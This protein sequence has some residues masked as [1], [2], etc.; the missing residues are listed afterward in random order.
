V[1]NSFCK[2]Q[3]TLLTSIL[4][5]TTY[6]YHPHGKE[7]EDMRSFAASFAM[8]HASTSLFNHGIGIAD[9]SGPRHHLLYGKL[10]TQQQHNSQVKKKRIVLASITMISRL[11]HAIRVPLQAM[12]GCG[13]LKPFTT[14]ER[15]C[16]SSSFGL[17]S[18][19]NSRS[20][21]SVSEEDIAE[22]TERLLQV[23]AD[24]G[25]SFNDIAKVLGLTNV[26]TT[27]LFLGQAKLST[28]AAKKLKEA[29]PAISDDDVRQMQT[30]FPM[31]VFDDDL[32]KEY[33]DEYVI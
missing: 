12:N 3:Y 7:L 21:S 31:R 19:Y 10:S 13:V 11:T 32:L 4:S 9:V 20:Y 25:K 1:Y 6:T 28:E 18:K 26:Y 33:V 5:L 24:S 8:R 16:P 15:R 22:R 17:L 29:L 23:K 27:Q 14:I 2:Y 30:S